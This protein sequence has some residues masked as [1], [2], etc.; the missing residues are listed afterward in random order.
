MTLYYISV[1]VDI[2]DTSLRTHGGGLTGGYK[3][4]Q[5]HFHWGADNTKGSE[6]V[7]D[8]KHYP[9]EVRELNII[10]LV[11]KCMGVIK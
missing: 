5:F 9:M 11:R 6:H 2:V 10:H 4:V 7:L 1:Q 3:P 8:N